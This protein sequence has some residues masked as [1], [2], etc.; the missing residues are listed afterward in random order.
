MLKTHVKVTS[1]RCVQ[2][3]FYPP[4]SCENQLAASQSI[5]GT[6]SKCSFRTAAT[7]MRAARYTSRYR[8]SSRLCSSNQPKFWDVQKLQRKI[9]DCVSSACCFHLWTCHHLEYICKIL[10]SLLHQ[11]DH[12]ADTCTATKSS[13][14][15]MQRVTCLVHDHIKFPDVLQCLTMISIGQTKLCAAPVLVI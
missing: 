1:T 11:W 14:V 6:I 10:L 5:V 9:P 3:K 15:F 2:Y 4:N 7:G 8:F 12:P 13:G